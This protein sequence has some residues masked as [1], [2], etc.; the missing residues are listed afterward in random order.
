MPL[1]PQV[2]PLSCCSAVCFGVALDMETN[3]WAK[4]EQSGYWLECQTPVS[5]YNHSG[6]STENRRK[7]LCFLQLHIILCRWQCNYPPMYSAGTSLRP[8][9]GPPKLHPTSYWQAE[10]EMNQWG[11][12]SS[13]GCRVS[14]ALVSLEHLLEE[15]G[16]EKLFSSQDLWGLR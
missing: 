4:A 13:S 11:V 14:G 16:S 5:L 9:T 12:L 8:S 15:D 7:W 10:A 1:S 6:T 3:R 2:F